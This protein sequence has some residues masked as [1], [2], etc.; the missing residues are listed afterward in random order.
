MVVKFFKCIKWE[1]LV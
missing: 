1:I